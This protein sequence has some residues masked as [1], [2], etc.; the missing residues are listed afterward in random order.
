[1]NENLKKLY[2]SLSSRGYYTKSFEDFQK[3]YQDP[4]YQDKVF[5]VVTRDGLYTKDKDSFISKYSPSADIMPQEELKKKEQLVSTGLPSAGISSGLPSKTTTDLEIAKAKAQGKYIAPTGTL[6][7]QVKAAGQA[8]IQ[9]KPKP[10]EGKPEAKPSEEDGQ[11]WALNTV[12]A[13]DRGFYKNLIGNPVKGLGTLLEKGTAKVFGGSG[14]GPISDALIKF[15]DYYNK[16][17]DELAPVDEEFKSSL[18]NQFS[19]A[20]GQLLSMALTGGVSS[21]GKT[22]AI[23]EMSTAAPATIAAKEFMK[24]LASPVSISAGLTIGQSEFD[25]AKQA[26][27]TDDQA[28][29][30]FYKNAVT[31]SVL[32]KIPVMQFLK[33]FNKASAGGV[34]NYLKTKTVAGLTGGT[35][36]M[37]TEILQQLYANKTAQ[38]IYNVNQDLFEGVG[39]SGGVGFGVGFLLNAMGANAKILRKSGREQEA[40][41]IEGQMKEFEKQAQ[42]GGQSSYSLN[43]IKVS[44]PKVLSDMIDNMSATDLAKLNVEITNDPEMATR[45][46][47]K[48]TNGTLKEQIRQANPDLNETSLNAIVELEKQLRALEGNTTQTGKDKASALRSQI[49]NIQENQLEE[50]VKVA[51]PKVETPEIT[52]KRTERITEL[53]T[54][55]S[56]P[57]NGKGTVTIGEELVPRTEL[58]TELQTLKTE[59]DAIQK[60]TAGQVP[61]QPTAGVSETVEVR[62][63]QTELEVTTKEG[64][65]KAEEVKPAEGQTRADIERRRQEKLDSVDIL[66]GG[67]LPIEGYEAFYK[68]VDEEY[69]AELAA[70]E[71]TTAK[72]QE[73]KPIEQ[74]VSELEQM[75]QTEGPIGENQG[76]SVSNKTQIS[77]LESKTTDTKKKGIIK[78]ATTAINTLKSIFPDMDIVIHDNEGSYNAQMGTVNGRA[79]SAGNFA[80]MKNADGKV[81]GGRIDI[82]LNKANM[83]TVAHEVAHAVMLK[84]FGDNT[85]L[86]KSFRNN[87]SKILSDS[88]VKALD[89][90]ASQYSESESHEE[91]LVELAA[92]L[93]ENE[94]QIP[95][96]TVQKI[97]EIINKVVSKITNG[98][99]QPFTGTVQTKELIDFLNTMSSA[100]GKGEAIEVAERG[101][102]EAKGEAGKIISK[103]SIKNIDVNKIR[104]LSRAG[105]RVSK[106]LAI[107]TVKNQKVVQEAE[108]LSL[109]YVKEKAPK[110]FIKNADLISK[111]PI[112]QGIKKFDKITNIQEAQE[113]YDIFT[114]QI[115]DNLKYLMDNF[116]KEFRD[117]ATL[118]YDGA[119][120]LAQNFSKK[121]GVSTEQA[122][123]IIASLSPQKDWYQNVRLAEMVMMAFKDNPIM[124]QEMVDKQ[125][126]IANIGLKEYTKALDKAKLAYKKSRSKA[127]AEK[128]KEEIK[129]NDEYTEKTEKVLK[130]LS[131]LVGTNMSSASP[132]MKGYYVRLFNEINTTKD[133]DILSPD[134]NVIGIA[135]KKNGKNAKVA[136]GSYTEIGKA[137]SIYLDGSQENI[138]RTLGEMHK[139]RNFYNNI[140]DPMSPDRD[141]TMDTHAVAAALMLPLSGKAKQVKA[142]FGTGTANSSPLGIKG[143]YYAFAEGYNLA[144][145][146]TGLLPRQVQSIT[147]EAVRG[148]FTDAFKRDSK[149]VAD[150]NQII[151]NYVNKKITLDEARKQ[152]TEY[153]GGIKDPSWAGGPL[154]EESADDAE[155]GAV[156]RGS[157]KDGSDTVGAKRRGQGGVTAV[158]KSQVA[159]EVKEMDDTFTVSKSQVDAY[160]GSP[161]DFDKFTTEKIGTGEG[162]QAFG[163]GLYFT[164]L[165]S[166]AEAYA[167]KLS[168]S[169]ALK[170][171]GKSRNELEGLHPMTKPFLLDLEKSTPKTKNEALNWLEKNK[172]GKSERVLN[173]LYELINDISILDTTKK[174]YDVSLFKDKTPDQYTWLEWDKP[175]SEKTKK[176]ILDFISSDTKYGHPTWIDAKR[177]IKYALENNLYYTN[178]DLYKTI[179]DISG[180]SPKSASLFLLD[181]GIDGVKYPAES[182][183]R[184]A[185][186]ENARGFNYVV[187]DENAVTIISKAQKA[188]NE[189]KKV[190]KEARAQ[191]YSE[192]GIKAFL[193]KKGLTEAEVDN[194]MKD[195]EAGKKIEL[196]EDLMPGYDK[197][198]EDVDNKILDG[199][200]RN[201]KN[202]TILANVMKVVEQSDA[203]KNATDQQREQIVRDVRKAF[204]EKIKKA[205]SAKKLLGFLKDVKKVT[206][207]EM[208]LL[209]KQ[210]KDMAKGAKTAKKAIASASKELTESLKALEKKGDITTKQMFAV[211]R[212]LNK[213]NLLDSASVEK[214]VDYMAKVFSDAEYADKIMKAFSQI[215]TAKKNIRTKIGISEQLYP[216][217]NRMFSMNP[218][219]IPDSVFEKYLEL[220]DMFAQKEKVLTLKNKEEVTALANDI[221]NAID[222]ELSLSEELAIRFSD[223]QDKVLD[224]NGKLD[225]AATIEA[226]LKDQTITDDE[227]KLMRKYKSKILPPAQ[228][229]KK[230]DAELEQEK[231]DLLEA[232]NGVEI[233]TENLPTND[234]RE[235]A[236]KL[237]RLIKSDAVKEMSIE[238]LTNLLKVIDNINNGYLPHYAQ[239]ILERLN[240]IDKGIALSNA[241][242]KAKPLSLTKVYTNIKGIFTR[243]DSISE[244]IRRS[245][246]YYI[247]QLFGNFKTKDIFDSLFKSAAEAETLFKSNITKIQN[248]LDEAQT[249]V[250]KSFGNRPNET[251]MSKFKM[252]TYMIQLEYLS[253]P[254]SKQVNPASEYL[255]AT[256][257]HIDGGKSSFGERDAE[258]LQEILDTYKDADGNI[259]IDKLYKSFNSAEKKAIATI[260]EINDSLADKAVH[261][262]AIIRGDKINLLENYVHLNVLHDA[263]PDDEISGV[264][265]AAAYNESLK[266]STKAKS[267]ISR[268]GKVAPLNFDVFASAQRGAKFVLMDYYLTEPIRTARK[269]INEATAMMEKDGRIPKEKRQILNAINSAFEETTENL[270]NNVFITNS[271]ADE[272]SNYLSKSGY[273]AVLASVPR[274]IAELGSNISFALF[275]DPKALTTGFK[276]RDVAMSSDAVKILNNLG[277]KQTN[278]IFPNE[279]L[280]GRLIDSSIMSQASGIKGGRAK[281]DVAN[282]IQ[283]LYNNSLKKFKNSVETLADTL[284]STP[285]KIVMRPLWIGSFANEFKRITGTDIDFDKIA[286]NDTDYIL[287]NKDALDDAR[288][289]ADQRSVLTGATDNPYMDI[290]K[291]KVKPNQSALTRAFN[292]FNNYMTRFAIYEY[293]TAR[294]GIMAAM[295]NGSLSRKQGVALMAGATS[296]MILY[297]LLAQSL[298]DE[299]VGLFSDDEEEEDEKSLGKK[300]GQAMTSTFTSL[301]IGRDFGNATKT[302]VNYGL[303]RMNEKY[304]DNLRE[305]EYDPYKDAIQYTIVPPD[306]KGKKT[307]LNDFL[308]NM[309]GPFGPS[310]KTAN[311]IARKLTED[312]KKKEDAIERSEKEVNVRIPLEILGNAGL[313]PLY[314]D[315]RK[316]VMKNIYKDLEK[317]EKSPETKQ[318]DFKPYGLNKEE[319]KKYMPDL[320]EQYYGEGTDY[321]KTSAKKRELRKKKEELRKK[322]LDERYNYIP[323]KKKEFGSSEFGGSELGSSKTT[324]S[325]KKGFGSSEFGSK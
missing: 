2:E 249:A 92:V 10:A 36:E 134:G 53:E 42:N 246:L 299:M 297:T 261:T 52:A 199:L 197:M 19:D 107:N 140:I 91:F 64:E 96:S 212:K 15:G 149:K 123:G 22:A 41:L 203:Y 101:A 280:A 154:Q 50:E 66:K 207:D 320:Y 34:A 62:K 83:R 276:Y 233:D 204:G 128:L 26:G 278:R 155:T 153:A 158:S 55:L 225:Y 71:A 141:V 86:F 114:R 291:G 234:E 87:I 11:S 260:K 108:D 29:E 130:E 98:R 60:Q 6:Q 251:L 237:E 277:S 220:L 33:R 259:D 27:A 314:K 229:A 74:E 100:I 200:N 164:D 176:S 90:F 133:Y 57:D 124:T 54:V 313:V 38:D 268:T 166:I 163:W 254:N 300:L 296:R 173:E 215:K 63:P 294:T 3:Q 289:I 49:K 272:V 58:E 306:A 189:I 84:S 325:K 73:V 28:F 265:S 39:E 323:S 216:L 179:A 324:S 240:A 143:L 263:K 119:N 165:K 14:K 273:R 292:I 161:Y 167:D 137:V 35:E 248:K 232:L 231:Q 156:G 129:S 253:N 44:D 266:P 286:N 210:F 97:A 219:M 103:S 182:L 201:A 150:V 81:V 208:V 7:E 121:Y 116:K 175:V 221:V 217:L 79:G 88:N 322:I 309:G 8:A 242:D 243:K 316:V 17:I 241:I 191:G 283:M 45:F 181:A 43:G 187:F 238:Q 195:A 32:E 267:L 194:L 301:L 250:A 78:A 213:T 151:E 125:K 222:E 94:Q 308:M 288:D 31:G 106:G 152:I 109:E 37:T 159:D 82:N 239:L 21:A 126:E 18:S 25:R 115:A 186:S 132:E 85:A 139:I 168:A 307:D 1:M 269:T 224:E 23:A 196:K 303:E 236:R 69:K 282:V 180:L 169:K 110:L 271:F 304:L 117:I 257:K 311:L 226:M 105:N 30:A 93:T 321:K 131:T 59:Q 40:Q 99:L 298:S 136:W 185:T 170:Y 290:L 20:F 258:M 318:D 120:I 5:G 228:K 245:P 4:A 255:K 319:L 112:V 218:N 252:M 89:D 317:A 142:N 102:V 211:L 72:D 77:N 188:A 76:V 206:M 177:K 284:I 75:F 262:S 138:T 146:E 46:Q 247:D 305:G 48:V 9:S 68:K 113:V 310:L 70:L 12:S 270:L 184:G 193:I 162:A 104:T 287:E 209:K 16:T 174:V 205:P 127:N 293:T 147:W 312:P 13:L 157:R 274:F 160:H 183:A 190:I 65:A 315:V 192:A 111:Y 61:V 295:G 227:A 279:A 202:E 285:D 275:T 178:E 302:F 95:T 67:R 281:S 264:T 118:W 80:V 145:K 244:M 148:L 24:D 256:I 51:T 144:A 223:Y 47:E 56:Q 214:F 230:T 135:K 122:A 172:R 171:G 235:V 198:M